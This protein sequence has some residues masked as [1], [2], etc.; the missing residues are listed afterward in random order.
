MLMLK[1]FMKIFKKTEKTFN[2]VV[3]VSVVP[4]T[5]ERSIIREI[6]YSVKRNRSVDMVL[7]EE[8]GTTFAEIISERGYHIARNTIPDNGLYTYNFWK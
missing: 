7:S 2:P 5:K 3:N 6:L 8:T 1:S 4:T